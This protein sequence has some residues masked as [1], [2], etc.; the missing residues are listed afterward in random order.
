[1]PKLNFPTI[2][3]AE[4]YSLIP[5]GIPVYHRDVAGIF[6]GEV[7]YAEDYERILAWVRDHGEEAR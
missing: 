4:D 7:D 1:M 2:P 6:W 5:E 3:D